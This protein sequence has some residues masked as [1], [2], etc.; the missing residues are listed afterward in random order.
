MSEDKTIHDDCENYVKSK[1]MCLKWFEKGISN[2]SQYDTCA[3]KIVYSDGE[4]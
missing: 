2:V 1:D 4:L 3:E